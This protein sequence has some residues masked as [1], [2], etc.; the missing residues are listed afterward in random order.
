MMQ[1]DFVNMVTHL[2]T[3]EIP[4]KVKDHVLKTYIKTDAWKI[5]DITKASTAAGALA[6]WA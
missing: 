5:A 1:K 4:V 2:N 3:S 6:L